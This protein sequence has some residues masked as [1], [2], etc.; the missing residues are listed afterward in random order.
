MDKKTLHCIIGEM[1][2]MDMGAVWDSCVSLQRALS[3]RGLLC[4]VLFCD[5]TFLL[6]FIFSR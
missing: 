3:K 2:T 1:V 6:V 4:C 5:E